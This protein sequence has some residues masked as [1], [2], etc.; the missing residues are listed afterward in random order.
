MNDG[1]SAEAGGG[2]GG[3]ARVLG[4]LSFSAGAG[5]WA[6]ASSEAA[7]SAEPALDAGARGAAL[8]RWL[9]AR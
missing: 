9:C 1:C 7:A 6:A 3:A 4:C 5:A 2:A 8:G